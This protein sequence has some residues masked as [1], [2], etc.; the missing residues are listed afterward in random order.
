MSNKAQEEFISKAKKEIQQKIKTEN[1]A[2]DEL[3]NEKKELMTAIQGYENF[4][5]DLRHFFIESM[6]DFVV[7][8]EDL[9]KYFRSNIND[10]YQNYAQIRR[11]AI[12]E[13]NTLKKYI[14]HCK[15]EINSNKRTL[16]FY[17]SQYMDSDFFDECLPLVEIYQKKIELYQENGKLTIKTIE[18]LEKIV[19]KLKGWE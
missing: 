8:E 2:L 13:I 7:A 15:K 19:E 17:R 10:V 9:P 1:K 5:H 3:N 18:K 14:N 12:D 16:K 4:H 6:Q 11:D